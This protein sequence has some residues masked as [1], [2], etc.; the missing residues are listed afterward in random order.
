VCI[1]ECIKY[2]LNRRAFGKRLSDIQSLRMKISAM[3]RMV[4]S[5]QAWLELVTYQM[6]TMS[7]AEANAKIGDVISLLK[8]QG[9]KVYEYCARETTMIFG[10]NALYI[11]GVGRKI[12]LAV[13][14]VKSY[15]IPAGAEDVMDDFASRVAFKTALKM[16]KL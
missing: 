6:C 3:A 13:G 11:N 2:A 16:A 9:S 5:Y 4:E 7:H 8:V 1:E 10:G 15:Q 14:Q 12:V